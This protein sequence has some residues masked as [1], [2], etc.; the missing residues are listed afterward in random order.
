[1]GFAQIRYAGQSITPITDQATID[2][3][4]RITGRRDWNSYQIPTTA[5][6]CGEGWFLVDATTMQAIIDAVGLPDSAASYADAELHDGDNDPVDLR[7]LSLGPKTHPIHTGLSGGLFCLHLQDPRANA[8]Q[9][10]HS[11]QDYYN[12]SAQNGSTIIEASLNEGGLEWGWIDVA[13]DAF[14]DG[15]RAQGFATSTLSLTAP[16]GDPAMKPRDLYFPVSPASSVVDLIAA[17]NGWVFCFNPYDSTCR[18]EDYGPFTGPSGYDLLSQLAKDGTLGPAVYLRG[19][20]QHR[21]YL[22]RPADRE[23]LLRAH[24]SALPLSSYPEAVVVVFPNR[25]QTSMA[26]SPEDPPP[27]ASPPED[28]PPASNDV[29]GPGSDVISVMQ[30]TTRTVD[31]TEAV[32]SSDCPEQAQASEISS[33]IGGLAQANTRIVHRDSVYALLESEAPYAVTNLTN[34]QCRAD[35]L[36]Q[37]V[38]GMALTPRGVAEYAGWVPVVPS[39]QVRRVV[40]SLGS[41]GPTT[42]VECGATCS[43]FLATQ[44]DGRPPGI[45]VGGAAGTQVWQRADGASMV[46][47]GSGAGGL[48]IREEAA[49]VDLDLFDLVPGPGDVCN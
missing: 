32:I 29:T 21:N 47:G 11:A 7:N 33:Q 14:V 27:E 48:T 45:Q 40:F 10:L 35:Y 42:R 25:F 24:L 34:L 9:L 28:S 26:S 31:I 46:M 17:A 37:R 2:L 36:A 1:M 8:V 3:A 16:A 19:G 43:Q 44:I 18:L 30:F 15:L 39:R 4:C 12:I 13:N 6:H 38:A 20:F 41:D 49:S 23:S 5:L 22:E